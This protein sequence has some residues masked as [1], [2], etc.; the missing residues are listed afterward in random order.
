MS[1]LLYA[2]D[3]V[4]CGESEEDLR[5]MMGRFSEVCRRRGLKVYAGKS[6]VMVLNR[7]EE[8][9][10]EVHVGGI[11]LEHDSEFK[12]LE[13]VLDELGT[14]RAECSRKVVSG[15]GVAGAIRSLVNARDLKLEFASLA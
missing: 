8:L 7:E 3:L 11:H 1:G 4:L 10:C 5:V 6:K 15:K 9:E 2:N 14:N 13:C 12:Y